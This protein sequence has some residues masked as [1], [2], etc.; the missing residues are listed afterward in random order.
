[1]P[2]AV[3][4]KEQGGW[5]LTCLYSRSAST[6][7]APNLSTSLYMSRV[8][9]E[10]PRQLANTKSGSC[11]PL[12]KSLMAVAVLYALSGNHTCPACQPTCRFE[13]TRER[14]RVSR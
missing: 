13:S 10:K 6:I 9:P 1:M 7:M 12:L 3:A 8:P 5:L 2:P 14:E 4:T 11:S